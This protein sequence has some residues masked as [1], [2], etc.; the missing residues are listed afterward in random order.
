MDPV[1]IDRD[2][3]NLRDL[4]RFVFTE[5]ALFKRLLAELGME[6]AEET[7]PRREDAVYAKVLVAFE[8]SQKACREFEAA[9]CDRPDVVRDMQNGLREEIK[10]WF[11]KSWIANRALAK[12]SGFVG[13]YEMLI[14]LYDEVTP[15]TGLGGYI[16]LCILDLPLAR[17]VRT[18]LKAAREFVL[19]EIAQRGGDIR[20]LDVASGPC[21]EYMGWPHVPGQGNVEIVVMDNDPKALAFVESEVATQMP[22]GT[23]LKP[24]RYNALRT[25]SAEATIRNFGQFDIIY[26]VGLCDYLDDDQLISML[27]GWRETLREGGVMLVAFKDTVQYDKTPYQWH[28]N[29]FFFQRTEED[30]LKL[31]EQAGFDMEN[32]A[33][34]R[35]GTGII[36][37]FVSRRPKGNLVRKDAAEGVVGSH[38]THI[39]TSAAMPAQE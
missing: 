11:D 2:T 21:R 36:I 20:V 29:W 4:E 38:K 22:K 32:M 10:V 30:C 15:A 35:D 24:V 9:N 1:S 26:S 18:R 25:R 16:D 6:I 27:R 33:V 14:K 12:P 37:N 34:S 19:A 17:A 8:A 23:E 13:D 39:P 5:V 7:L 28:L 31:F 3:A